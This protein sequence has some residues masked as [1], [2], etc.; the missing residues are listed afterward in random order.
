MIITLFFVALIVSGI[1]ICAY[2]EHVYGYGLNGYTLL[3]DTYGVI[4]LFICFIF[5]MYAHVGVENSIEIAQIRRAGIEQ[6]YEAINSQYEDIS[7]VTVL[8]EVEE[9]N[10]EVTSDRYWCDN[11]M[12]SWFFS[13]KYVQSLELI[14]TTK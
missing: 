7:K 2:E 4:G 11:P 12:T 14:D 13:K 8:Q 1:V 5:I 10:K 6:R 3:A 9:W